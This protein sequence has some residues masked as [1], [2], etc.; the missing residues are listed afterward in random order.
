MKVRASQQ[1][2]NHVWFPFGI[3]LYVR[4]YEQ[5]GIARWGCPA[6]ARNDRGLHPKEMRG[7]IG[8]YSSSLSLEGYQ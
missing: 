2:K 5:I 1:A 7:P 8:I 6:H 4:I 3:M